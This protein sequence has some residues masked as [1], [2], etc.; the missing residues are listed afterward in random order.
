MSPPVAP[1][2]KLTLPDGALCLVCC[3]EAHHK[4]GGARACASRL[5]L[6]GAQTRLRLDRPHLPYTLRVH[7][8][9]AKEIGDLVNSHIWRDVLQLNAAIIQPLLRC[10]L[11]PG[12]SIILQ[13]LH[14]HPRAS[15]VY[16]LK[17]QQTL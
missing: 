5:S 6:P 14:F 16:S 17:L 13:C 11:Q 12:G 7:L 15:R 9:I 1:P 3:G 4:A 10:Q 2:L 8:E